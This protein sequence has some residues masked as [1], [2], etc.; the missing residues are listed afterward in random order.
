MSLEQFTLF[1]MN[2]NLKLSEYTPIELNDIIGRFKVFIE[3]IKTKN[4]LK[5]SGRNLL[6]MRKR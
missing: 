6:I 4:L 1:W 3:K 2:K 5:N